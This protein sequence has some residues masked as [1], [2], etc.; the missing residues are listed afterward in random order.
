M[1]FYKKTTEREIFVKKASDPFA[2]VRSRAAELVAQMT[3]EEKA[4]LCSGQNFWMTHGVERLGLAPVMVTDGPHGLR[5]QAVAADHLGLNESMPATC[6]PPAC[7]TACAFDPDLAEDIGKAMGEECR[8]EN[9]AVLLGPAAGQSLPPGAGA[10][11]LPQGVFAARRERR[12]GVHPLPP[13]LC[14]L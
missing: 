9:V 12:G 1:V 4:A 7:A 13:R 3:R 2:A 10:A 5:K 6:F 11:G 14:L 8:Q